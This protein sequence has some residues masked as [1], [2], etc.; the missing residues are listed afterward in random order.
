MTYQQYQNYNSTLELAAII[1]F[2]AIAS[3]SALVKYCHQVLAYS[4]QL[5][6]KELWV[7]HFS[8]EGDII[9]TPYWTTK[10]GGLFD[11]FDIK[12]NHKK[13]QIG[14]QIINDLKRNFNKIS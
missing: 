6:S 2:I 4:R 1:E 8:H 7:V 13:C 11:N 3:Y 10:E 5:L 12:V 9:S 14:L